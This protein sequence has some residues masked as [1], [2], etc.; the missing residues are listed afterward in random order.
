MLEVNNIYNMDCL[1]GLKL[2]SDNS[3]DLVVTSPP[4][5]MRTRIRNG[6]YTTREKSE[7]FS[8]KYEHFSDDLTIEEYYEF[9]KNVLT[10][11]LRV[12][13]CVLWNY[14]IVTGSKSAVFKLIGDFADQIKDIIIWEKTGQPAMHEQVLNSCYEFIIIFE[15]DNKKGRCITNSQFKRGTMNNVLKGYKKN[16]NIKGH[17]ACFPV[18]LVKDLVNAFSKEGDIVLDPFMGSGTT[19]VA[20]LECNR[21]YI[22]FEIIQEYV[23]FANDRIQKLGLKDTDGLW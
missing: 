4:Y 1:E 3:I 20:A 10:E 19:A 13:K 2:L 21:K 22:G 9:H 11:L 15:G 18:E 16:N 12:S 14:Q 23:D 7:H 17:G 5:N 8:K 6:E